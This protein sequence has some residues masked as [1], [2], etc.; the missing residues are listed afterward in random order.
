MSSYEDAWEKNQADLKKLAKFERRLEKKMLRPH[1]VG[2]G[3]GRLKALAE[4]FGHSAVEAAGGLLDRTVTPYEENDSIY[5]QKRRH[6]CSEAAARA[7]VPTCID[8]SVAA[9]AESIP[10]TVNQLID[11]WK[12]LSE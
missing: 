11:E 6:E 5:L 8:A 3:L 9:V 7:I 1:S 12:T 2:E 4:N 10:D